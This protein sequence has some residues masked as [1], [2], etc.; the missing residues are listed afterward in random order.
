MRRGRVRRAPERR[1]RDNGGT[2]RKKEPLGKKRKRRV[3]ERDKERREK[4]KRRRRSL[5]EPSFV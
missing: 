4:E 5:K 3:G 1:V 2:L